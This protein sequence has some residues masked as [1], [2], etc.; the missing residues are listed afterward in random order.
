M[1]QTD[2]RPGFRL[3]WTAERSDSDQPAEAAATETPVAEETSSAEELVTTDMIEATATAGRRNAPRQFMAELRPSSWPSSAARCRSPPR[4]RAT[5]RWPASPPTRRRSSK[6]S[7]PPRPSRPPRCAAEPT[8][9]S[10]PSASGRRPRSPGSA[11]RPRH[12]SPRARPRSTARWTPTAGSSR[13]A[14][15]GS[16]RPSPN[17][18]AG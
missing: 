13:P 8:T 15:S 10:P 9:M 6:R 5:R 11:K 3:P 16:T 2:T 12:A 14:S 17:S 18:K 1:A 4:A 7:T